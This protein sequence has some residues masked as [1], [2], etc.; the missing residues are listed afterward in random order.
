M[1]RLARATARPF[2]LI[3]FVP[4]LHFSILVLFCSSSTPVSLSYFIFAVPMR[5]CFGKH[6]CTSSTFL[7]AMLNGT[8]F[9]SS[10]E[11]IFVVVSSAIQLYKIIIIVG[12]QRLFVDTQA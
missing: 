10:L 5:E 2:R 12:A 4:T 7:T 11:V 1:G 9:L 8:C 3:L 6:W